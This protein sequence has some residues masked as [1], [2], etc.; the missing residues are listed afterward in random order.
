MKTVRRKIFQPA[1]RPVMVSHVVL[2]DSEKVVGW[3]A[4]RTHPTRY[5]VF[6][7]DEN[8]EPVAAGEV[9]FVRDVA[10]RVTATLRNRNVTP[11]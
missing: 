1:A 4:T 5:A 6:C 3:V 10:L 11:A 7:A 8:G 9:R 2:D